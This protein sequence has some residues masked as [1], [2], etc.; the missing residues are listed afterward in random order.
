MGILSW[1]VIGL[2][3]GSVARYLL[4]RDPTGPG[5]ILTILVGLAGALV[6]GFLATALGFGGVAAFD[7]QSL[8]TAT[9]GAILVLFVT[10]L[11]T[12]RR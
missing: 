10:R 4:W 7:V 3:A 8:V 2:L 5:C 11:A 9:L 6:G 1:L 12:A